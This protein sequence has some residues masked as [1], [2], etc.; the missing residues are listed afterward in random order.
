MDDNLWT[1]LTRWRYPA[2]VALQ[3]AGHLDTLDRA[4]YARF[5]QTIIRGARDLVVPGIDAYAVLISVDNEGGRVGSVV[6]D[7]EIEEE[8]EYWIL[9]GTIAPRGSCIGLNLQ[10]LLQDV[11]A[12]LTP[13]ARKAFR[14]F[15][16]DLKTKRDSGLI[17]SLSEALMR[18][19]PGV[20]GVDIWNEAVAKQLQE[21]LIRALLEDV[22]P[23]VLRQK[24]GKWTTDL[25]MS[26]TLVR[27]QDGKLLHIFSR[28]TPRSFYGEPHE[29]GGFDRDAI[30]H[31][32]EAQGAS[33]SR[34]PFDPDFEVSVRGCHF[35][36]PRIEEGENTVTILSVGSIGIFLRR[37]PS[38]RDYDGHDY[39]FVQSSFP[40]ISFE[41][42]FL[43]ALQ[44]DNRWV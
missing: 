42:L 4:C 43:F 20:V 13:E 11:V 17:P 35:S 40:L 38:R 24:G 31:D 5:M 2:A 26:A 9:L 44:A 28:L 22:G 39:G 7:L 16:R 25:R 19:G 1:A 37:N 36:Q 21:N 15:V 32:Q 41:Q 23:I 12:V 10:R 14:A 33:K 27:K 3:R 18:D 29:F 30:E 34:L 8:V 6:L